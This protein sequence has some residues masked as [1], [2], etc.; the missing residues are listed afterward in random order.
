MTDGVKGLNEIYQWLINIQARAPN[1]PCIIVGTHF[2]E[3]EQKRSIFGTKLVLLIL[4]GPCM[5][6]CLS[7]YVS[8]YLSAC[9]SVWSVCLV[10]LSLRSL[11][12]LKQV[13][14]KA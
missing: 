7:I 8:L 1:S 2:D 3:V 10:G 9:L 5:S 6:M 4:V 13:Y 12:M 14:G 11:A